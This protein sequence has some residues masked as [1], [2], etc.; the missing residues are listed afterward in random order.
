[1]AEVGAAYR[2]LVRKRAHFSCEYCG[3]PESLSF[4]EHQID[5]VIA[6]KHG[7]ASEPHNLALSCTLCNQFKGS[8]IASVDPETGQV[9]TLFHPRTQ[10]WEEHFRLDSNRIIGLTPSGRATTRLL[11]FNRPERLA[12]RLVQ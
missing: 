4:A 3:L 2:A 1:M 9:V 11:Q 12:E 5:H 10:L 7:G 6:I 8:D